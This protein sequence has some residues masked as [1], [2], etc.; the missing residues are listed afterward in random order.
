MSARYY[1]L[2]VIVCALS[3]FLVGMHVPALHEITEHGRAPAPGLA[4]ALVV[5]AV[6]ALAGL[7]LLLRAPAAARRPPGAS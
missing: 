6:S 5:L 3:W 2:T 4:F 7:W 1:R